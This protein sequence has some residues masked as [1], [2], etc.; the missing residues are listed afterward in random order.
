MICKFLGGWIDSFLHLVINQ[1]VCFKHAFVP[2]TF[3][4]LE[5]QN[6]G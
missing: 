5:Q 6:T 2:S 1:Q 4:G 3:L